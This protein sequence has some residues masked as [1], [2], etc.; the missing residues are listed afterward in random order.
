MIVTHSAQ[1]VREAWAAV[2]ASRKAYSEAQPATLAELRP[3][4]AAYRRACAAWAEL[5]RQEP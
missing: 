5:W 1:K 3:Y 4:W 2:E